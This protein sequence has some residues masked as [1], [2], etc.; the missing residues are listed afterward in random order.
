MNTEIGPG[1][2]GLTSATAGG[3][4]SS[5]DLTVA[6]LVTPV[7]RGARIA[8]AMASSAGLP[9]LSASVTGASVLLAANLSLSA[10]TLPALLGSAGV[11]SG[12]LFGS[13]GLNVNSRSSVIA[14]GVTSPPRVTMT[15]TPSLVMPQS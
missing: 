5:A 8:K 12:S 2:S 3:G 1:L 11:A 4:A 13:A 15:R 7:S 9:D 6:A 10:A 14:A